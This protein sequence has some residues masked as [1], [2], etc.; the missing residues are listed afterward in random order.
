MEIRKDFECVRDLLARLIEYS[1]Q[2]H[3]MDR[4]VWSQLK[5]EEDYNKISK[6]GT[7]ISQLIE[8]IYNEGRSFAGNMSEKL[9]GFNSV[10][11]Y[12]YFSLYVNDLENHLNEEWLLEPNSL[13][14]ILSNVS[15]AIKK[16]NIDLYAIDEM[17][18]LFKK[19]IV[20]KDGIIGW[21]QA[22]KQTEL[23]K[24]GAGLPIKAGTVSSFTS[25]KK[26]KQTPT[27]KINAMEKKEKL[28]EHYNWIKRHFDAHFF[29]GKNNELRFSCD[30]KEKVIEN[31]RNSKTMQLFDL[32]LDTDDVTDRD[33]RN[34][35]I[36]TEKSK[37][38]YVVRD[39]N[40]AVTRKIIPLFSDIPSDFQFI[41][42]DDESCSYKLIVKFNH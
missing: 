34:A 7:A 17:V 36:C 5:N 16:Y 24:A 27:P 38:N 28:Q 41:K 31:K 9:S 20:M 12:P 29:Y 21:I 37:P 25:G 33:I 13:D 1:E 40:R 35:K 22:A 8:P 11:D 15:D 32:F 2:F 3:K 18:I 42:Y 10:S 39:V 26:Q 19:Q 4:R 14:K 6:L 23:Y 30:G